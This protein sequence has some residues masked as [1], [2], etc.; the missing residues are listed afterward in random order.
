MIVILTVPYANM[1]FMK[2]AEA[3]VAGLPSSE[4]IMI[5]CVQYCR[6]S[7]VG[8][9]YPGMWRVLV[10]NGILLDLMTR[11]YQLHKK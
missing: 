4:K 9:I 3:V 5:W 8:E 2:G 1:A 7:F 11:A 6:R 10:E